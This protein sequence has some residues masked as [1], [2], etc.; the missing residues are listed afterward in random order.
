MSGH[1]LQI[2]LKLQHNTRAGVTR[3]TM[4][5]TP[6]CPAPV[7][8]E[9]C[10]L[11]KFFP[12]DNFGQLFNFIFY[13]RLEDGFRERVG[14]G[15][16]PLLLCGVLCCGGCGVVYVVGAFGSMMKQTVLGSCSASSCC[17]CG[18]AAKYDKM[19]REFGTLTR[20]RRGWGRDAV[21]GGGGLTAKQR[22][23]VLYRGNCQ[24]MPSL[25][26]HQRS[27]EFA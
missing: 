23:F 16:V 27:A 1:L 26:F 18:L 21:S 19:L 8:V 3:T 11:E 5:N 7:P 13:A 2:K 15:W 25:S 4:P 12:L 14:Y 22:H 10:Q 9:L 20:K 6:L 17:C 24:K